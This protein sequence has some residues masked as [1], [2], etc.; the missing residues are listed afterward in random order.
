[1]TG[2][3]AYEA[4]QAAVRSLEK[5]SERTGMAVDEL[6]RRWIAG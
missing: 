6:S 2:F 5:L 3:P 4:T 1:M